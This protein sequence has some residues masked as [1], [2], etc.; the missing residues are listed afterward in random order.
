MVG[1]FHVA[2]VVLAWT[3]SYMA[4]GENCSSDLLAFF[5]LH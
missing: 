2:V 4:E 3:P 5:S 1:I